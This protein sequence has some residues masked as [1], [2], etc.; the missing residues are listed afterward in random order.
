MK[1]PAMH[2]RWPMPEPSPEATAPT[3]LLHELDVFLDHS[4]VSFDPF[5]LLLP[6][7]GVVSGFDD[8]VLLTGTGRP[9]EPN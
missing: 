7:E 8:P 3:P 4:E 9:C 5:D 1:A 6:L 2:R